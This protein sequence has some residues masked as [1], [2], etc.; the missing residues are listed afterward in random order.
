MR[1]SRQLFFGLALPDDIKQQLIMWRATT[2][3]AD[4][5]YPVVADALSLPLAFLGDITPA[6]QQALIQL[7]GRIRQ[8]AFTL[9]LDDAGHWPRSGHVWLG[10]HHAPRGLLQLADM[11]R[12]Q[13]ARNGCYQ[14]PYPFHPHITLLRQVTQ[15]IKLPARQFCWSLPV[16]RFVLFQS[17]F[18]RG[19]NRIS[20]IQDW[21]LQ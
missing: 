11:L 10:P 18:S 17:V 6:K 4:I 5:G 12:A 1:G 3:P 8:P 20:E 21:A 7:A 13:A 2:F 15:P 19:K 14:A 16:S 9:Q